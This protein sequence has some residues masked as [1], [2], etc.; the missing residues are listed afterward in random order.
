MFLALP[1]RTQ[2]INRLGKAPPRPGSLRPPDPNRN[3]ILD[4]FSE[5]TEGDA[6]YARMVQDV[7]D[8]CSSTAACSML[9]SPD[10]ACPADGSTT[11]AN[12]V[13]A[14]ASRSRMCSR[15]G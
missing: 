11:W 14:S 1:S 13:A 2:G 6:D 12:N 9:F 15:A 4:I 10:R 3:R 5:G 8:A 7:S